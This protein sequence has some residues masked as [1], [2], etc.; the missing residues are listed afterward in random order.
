MI[1][2]LQILSTRVPLF[3]QAFSVCVILDA[4]PSGCS[5]FTLQAVS[6]SNPFGKTF[7]A[8]WIEDQ[9]Q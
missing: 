3:L 5:L 9:R 2:P 1:S 4:D 6:K 7:D 8:T